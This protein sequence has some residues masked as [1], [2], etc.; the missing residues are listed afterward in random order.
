MDLSK[1][2]NDIDN[3]D[4]QLITLINQRMSLAKDVAEYKKENSMPVFDAGREREI[5]NKVA[6]STETELSTYMQVLYSTLFNIS[7]S[8]QKSILSNANELKHEIEDAVNTTPKIFPQR[9]VVACQGVEGAYSQV[10]CDRLFS[11][12][13]ITYFKDFEGVFKSV[14]KG[15]CEYGLLPIENSTAGSVNEVYDLMKKYKFYVARSIQLRIEHN[16]L[17]KKGV[18]LEDIKEIYSHDQAIKQ[19]SEYLNHIGVKINV[20]ENTAIAAKM[21]AESDRTDIAA[22]SSSECAT[23]YNLNI[24]DSEIMNSENNYTRFICISKN[25]EIYPGANKVSIMFSLP[26]KP[27][28][29]YSIISSLSVLGINITKLESRPIPGKNF[30]FMF[31]FDIEA[32]VYSDDIIRILSELNDNLTQFVYLGSYSEIF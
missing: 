22:I 23:N 17:A 6:N 11:C 7:R 24:I 5:L 2:R 4:E 9:A 18:K 28:S 1:I 25:L 26:H 14:D 12:P 31:Y 21:V 3:I 30:E 27:G 15:L 10:A 16:L 32:N 8:Y 19:C 29:L 20:C 13:S